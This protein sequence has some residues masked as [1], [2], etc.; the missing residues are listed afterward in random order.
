MAAEMKNEQQLILLGFI[1]LKALGCGDHAAAP[2]MFTE[3]SEYQLD[4]SVSLD[5]YTLLRASLSSEIIH[6]CSYHGAV[7]WCFFF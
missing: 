7:E 2:S 5:I 6:S 1:G 3:M 4:N